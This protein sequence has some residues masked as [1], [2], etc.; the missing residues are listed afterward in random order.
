LPGKLSAGLI[1]RRVHGDLGE[2]RLKEYQRDVSGGET[3]RDYS[4]GASVIHF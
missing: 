4:A 1:R 2:E 3:A